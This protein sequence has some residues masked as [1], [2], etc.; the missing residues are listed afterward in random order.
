MY[1]LYSIYSFNVFR[2]KSDIFFFCNSRHKLFSPF[3]RSEQLTIFQTALNSSLEQFELH[4]FVPPTDTTPMWTTTARSSTSATQLSILMARLKWCSGLSSAAT[5][6]SSTSSPSP[7]LIQRTL[8]PAPAPG[9]S[10]TWMRTWALDPTFHSTT[11][12]MLP[13]LLLLHQGVQRRLSDQ[14]QL[15]FQDPKGEDHPLEVRW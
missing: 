15:Q 2:L 13:E 6:L 14:L 9:I 1:N 11:I 12:R 3:S 10:G 5:R 4:S 7:V 8:F